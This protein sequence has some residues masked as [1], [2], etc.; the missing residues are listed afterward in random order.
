MLIVLAAVSVFTPIIV[1][2]HGGNV[3]L[4]AAMT[5]FILFAA[6]YIFGFSILGGI[7][8]VYC[9]EKVVKK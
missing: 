1:V 7:I 4:L 2:G 5:F 9:K 6:I 8:G 3:R